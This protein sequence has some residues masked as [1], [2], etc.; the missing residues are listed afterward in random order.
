MKEGASG[1]DELAAIRSLYDRAAARYAAIDGGRL[2][3]WLLL[4][5]RQQAA[6]Y[7][8]GHLLEVGIGAGVTLALYPAEVR[9]TGI[10]V[11]P[12]MLAIARRR[13][14]ELGRD[15]DLH[16]MDAQR[17]DFDDHEFDS[18]A[19]NLCLCTIPDPARALREAIRVAKPGAPMTFL[20]HVRSDRPWVA[21]LQDLLNALF[22]RGIHDRINARTEDVIRAAGIEI[23]SVDRWAL[24]LMTLIVGHAPQG[25]DR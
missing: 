8:R 17:L 22:S 2:S 12:G 13:L 18:V 14:S 7:A 6:G 11:S 9:V 4:K 19:F 25:R 20:E 16:E 3:R 5:K 15:G 10:D 24:G 1:D 23:Q 21:I